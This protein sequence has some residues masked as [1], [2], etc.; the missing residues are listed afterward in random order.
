MPA[1]VE[2]GELIS[3]QTTKKAA[4]AKAATYKNIF[5]LDTTT[6]QPDIQRESPIMCLACGLPLMDDE[7]MYELPNGKLVHHNDDCLEAAT[8]IVAAHRVNLFKEVVQ[9]A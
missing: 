1:E 7:D 6:K 4:R 8:G 2:K 9:S 5:H 3:M